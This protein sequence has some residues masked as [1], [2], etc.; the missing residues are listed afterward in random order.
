MNLKVIVQVHSNS[1][2]FQSLKWADFDEKVDGLYLA[3]SFVKFHSLVLEKP[4]S[5]PPQ[6]HYEKL[7]SRILARNLRGTL[8]HQNQLQA[9]ECTASSCE[10]ALLGPGLE[11]AALWRPSAG[12]PSKKPA[13]PFLTFN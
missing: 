3:F 5:N 2:S 10:N 8:F 9:V 7:H 12:T 6:Y 1:V 4:D 13:S 11:V